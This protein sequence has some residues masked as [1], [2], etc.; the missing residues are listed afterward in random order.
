MII[1]AAA[2]ALTMGAK[3]DKIPPDTKLEYPQYARKSD[4]RSLSRS[5]YGDRLQGFW[6][7]E[8]IAN[9]TGLTT[10]GVRKTAPFFTDEDWGTKQGKKGKLIVFVLVGEGKAWGSDDDTDIEYIYQEALHARGKSIL[11]PE[12]SVTHG[13]GT[14]RRRSRTSCGYP[15]RKRCI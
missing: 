4:D 14:S 2:A 1:G 15:T 8:C 3:A 10:E 5:A 9:W 12:T 7:G 11:T 6:L 13:W